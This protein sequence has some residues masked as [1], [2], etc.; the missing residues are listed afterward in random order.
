VS[1][2]TRLAVSFC[3]IIIGGIWDIICDIMLPAIMPPALAV[4][5]LSVVDPG[6]GAVWS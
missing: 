5:A 3:A 1:R 6:G 2:S 4:S